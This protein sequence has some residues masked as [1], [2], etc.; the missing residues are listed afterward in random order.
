MFREIT[1]G[2]DSLLLVIRKIQGTDERL[3]GGPSLILNICFAIFQKAYGQQVLFLILV[4]PNFYYIFRC[5][6][7]YI[8][9]DD[10][11]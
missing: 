10:F 3:N 11:L 8:Y 9:N 4:V 5:T 1:Q 7:V 6:H 2:I